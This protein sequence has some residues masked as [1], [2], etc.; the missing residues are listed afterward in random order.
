MNLHP[1][2]L[3]ED[4]DETGDEN[5]SQASE[6]SDGEVIFVGENVANEEPDPNQVHK[7]HDDDFETIETAENEGAEEGVPDGQQPGGASEGAPDGEQLGRGRRK[8]KM[9]RRLVEDEAWGQ[10][11]AGLHEE[12]KLSIPTPKCKKPEW[13]DDKTWKIKDISIHINPSYMDSAK[14][15]LKVTNKLPEAD[16]D[17]VNHTNIGEAQECTSEKALIEDHVVM[18]MLGVI[19]A[20][21]YSIKEGIKLFGDKGRESIMKELQQLHDMVI[22]MPIHA[23]ELTREQRKEALVS[24]MFL[25]EKRC[26][27]LKTRACANGSKQRQWIRKED[28]ASPTVMT[29]SVVITSAIEAHEYRKII[30]LN[31]PGAFLHADLD[32]EVIMVLRGEL[33]E[34]MVT[35]NPTTP[36]RADV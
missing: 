22:Y 4:D 14:Q 28:A 33:A 23:H 7:V 2:I 31:I 9:T 10:N 21:Q 27:R 18:H 13:G 11:H 36:V 15:A 5:A 6:E 25:T 20:H 12:I 29:D 1:P 26:S 34:L 30:T 8:K 17:G 24:L 19:F 32:E 3:I 35:I 16:T